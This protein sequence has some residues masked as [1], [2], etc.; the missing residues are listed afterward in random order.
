MRAIITIGLASL[1]CTRSP[2][3]RREPVTSARAV[4]APVPTQPE[5]ARE[6]PTENDAAAPVVI[7]SETCADNAVVQ[8]AMPAIESGATIVCR[9]GDAGTGFTVPASNDSVRRLAFLR[10]A[11]VRRLIFG[12][13]ERGYQR[14]MRRM[15]TEFET[16]A[17]QWVTPGLIFRAPDRASLHLVRLDGVVQD[18]H[19]GDGVTEMTVTTDLIGRERFRVIVPGIAA[20]WVVA[21]VGVRLYGMYANDDVTTSHL[22]GEAHVPVIYAVVTTPLS[23]RRRGY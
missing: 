19:E 22:T 12:M 14:E 1:A 5:S 20:D 18:V 4:A 9:A 13:T 16:G 8:Q 7:E 2:E 3:P 23:T 17:R 15:D 11:V 6:A 10:A 21:H